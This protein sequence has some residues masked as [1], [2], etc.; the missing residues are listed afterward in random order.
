[1][2]ATSSGDATTIRNDVPVRL[3]VSVHD[4]LA[5][6]KGALN[7]REQAALH[8]IHR[9]TMFRLRSGERVASLELAMKMAADL[10]VPVEVLFERTRTVDR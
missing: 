5:A 7:V 9:S 8:G 6:R 10:D 1:M 4:A 3:R 2:T